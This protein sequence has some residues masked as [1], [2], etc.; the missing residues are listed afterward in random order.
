MGEKGMTDEAKSEF[1]K[2]MNIDLNEAVTKN[3]L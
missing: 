3:G 1:K 2:A